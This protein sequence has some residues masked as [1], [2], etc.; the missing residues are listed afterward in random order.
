VALLAGVEKTG[1]LVTCQLLA[2]QVMVGWAVSHPSLRSGQVPTATPEPGV[3]PFAT[4]DT[5]AGQVA[6][7]QSSRPN[8]SPG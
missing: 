7:S 5:A 2:A 6:A 8:N 3:R 1:G 4:L